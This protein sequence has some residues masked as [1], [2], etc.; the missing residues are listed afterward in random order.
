MATPP[1][2]ASHNEAMPEWIERLLAKLD[3]LRHAD[4]EFLVTGA[5]SHWYRFGPTLT[6]TWL[7]WLEAKYGIDLPDQYRQFLLTVGNGGAGPNYGLQRFGY[8]DGPHQVPVSFGTGA[9]CQTVYPS[10][11]RRRYEERY[12]PD[13]V[14]FDGFDEN[15]YDSMRML[16]G[17]SSILAEPF[18]FT[19]ERHTNEHVEA[20]LA[21]SFARFGKQGR[22]WVPGALYV[23]IYG[24]GSIE[25]LV[26][27]GRWKGTIWADSLANDGGFFL[28]AE[29]FEEWYHLWMDQSLQF[30]ARS[31]NYRRLLSLFATNDPAEAR[32]LEGLLRA[33][34]IRCEVEIRP[35][36][37][38]I[39]LVN[40]DQADAA[41]PLIADFVSRKKQEQ[42]AGNGT[43]GG[44]GSS[45]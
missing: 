1:A 24:C 35:S 42:S 4:P 18:P 45:Q 26:L 27:N 22:W 31:L 38:I 15:L 37:T 17:G 36:R 44:S 23:S 14:P 13:G 30:C 21:D 9:M 29:S 20:T 40:L 6:P 12:T 2:H 34:A 10:G 7:A 33:R 3:R 43:D 32:E 39:V 8:L 19:E 41:R 28:V 11:F 5:S 25:M 16:A